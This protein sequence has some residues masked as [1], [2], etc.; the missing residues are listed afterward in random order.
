MGH[1]LVLEARLLEMINVSFDL[2]HR[3][4]QRF[5]EI[6]GNHEAARNEREVDF[7]FSTL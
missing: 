1:R 7:F 2:I 4:C 3:I 5:D 6:R